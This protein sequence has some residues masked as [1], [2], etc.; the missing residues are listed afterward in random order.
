[1]QLATNILAHVMENV[2]GIMDVL[3]TTHNMNMIAHATNP[4]TDM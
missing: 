3:V 4:V 2:M 1:M